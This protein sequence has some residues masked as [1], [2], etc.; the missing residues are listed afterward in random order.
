MT[1]LNVLLKTIA[2]SKAN[3][4]HLHRAAQRGGELAPQYMRQRKANR[5]EATEH[6]PNRFKMNRWQW[7]HITLYRI[8]LNRV[9]WTGRKAPPTSQSANQPTNPNKTIQ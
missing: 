5:E 6:K 9:D 3:W 2:A 8:E 7:N 1:M 4:H